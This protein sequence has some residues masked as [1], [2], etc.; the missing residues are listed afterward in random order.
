M[1]TPGSCSQFPAWCTQP[2]MVQRRRTQNSARHVAQSR[3]R[4]TNTAQHKNESTNTHA[5][6]QRGQ[7]K[8]E[9]MAYPRS[10]FKLESASFR[11]C[12]HAPIK[13]IEKHGEEKFKVENQRSKHVQRLL[14]NALHMHPHSA[15]KTT[16]SLSPHTSRGPTHVAP[17]AF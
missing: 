16:Q 10:E 11:N 1:R 17:V 9:N 15:T 3:C 4:K 8:H 13:I 12:S 14:T 2:N 6:D 7:M 5:V